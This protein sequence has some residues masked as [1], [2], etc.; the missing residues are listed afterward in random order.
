MD[1]AYLRDRHRIGDGPC[2]SACRRKRR[3]ACMERLGRTLGSGV[4]PATRPREHA[5]MSRCL[6]LAVLL[7]ATPAAAAPTLIKA[8]HL[9]DGVSDRPRDGVAVLVDGDAIVALG[10]PAE[11][12]A[13]YP[14][15]RV[16]DL[17]GATLLPGLI[18]A[19]THVFLND[20]VGPGVYDAILLKDSTPYRAIAAA[21]NARTALGYGFTAIR[22]LETEGAMYADVDVRNAIARGV[23]PG[24]RM[25]VATRA[26][27]PTGMYPLRGYSW[28]LAVPIGVQTIDGPEQARKAVREQVG[29]GA[30][31]I[32]YY[33]DH[34][35]YEGRPDRPVRS[36]VNFTAA[37][38]EAVV[39]EA[40]RLGVKVAAHANGWD[41]IDAALR[42]GVDSIE[43]GQ[44]LTDDL[45]AR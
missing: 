13:K 34:G 11:L 1:E 19:H 43:H 17:G 42:A 45:I 28:E 32:K 6:L 22:D 38:A 12:T 21:A 8:A 35:V 14:G 44:G 36:I 7:A 26:L 33:A 25:W 40:H 2:R 18:D 27:A 31:W 29:F 16:I 24:P 15:A 39:D 9:I 37:E 41:G 4:A 30:D 3:R 23:V 5:R 10:T 20:D